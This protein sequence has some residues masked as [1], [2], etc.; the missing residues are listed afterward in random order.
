MTVY[1][2]PVAY[3]QLKRKND[4][5]VHVLYFCV[6]TNFLKKQFFVAGDVLCQLPNTGAGTWLNASIKNL[7]KYSETAAGMS[8]KQKAVIFHMDQ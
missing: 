8:F 3:I 6:P 7:A 4:E 1:Y 2:G 5:D